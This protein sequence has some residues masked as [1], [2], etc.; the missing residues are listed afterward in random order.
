MKC[1]VTFLQQNIVAQVPAGTT[2]FDAANWAGLPI[3][4]TCGG[5]GACGKCKVKILQGANAQTKSDN[6]FLSSEESA[7]GW[8]LSCQAVVHADT[9]V[10][11]LRMMAAPKAATLVTGRKV[12]LDPNVRKF[13]LELP[14]PSLEDQR[15]DVKRVID[16]LNAKGF[17]V[18]AVPAVWRKLPTL[19][20]ENN[21]AITA[22]V[23]GDE[24]IAIEAG[25]TT[26]CVYGLA[27]DIGTTTVV[28]A[29]I[30]L[31]SGDVVAVQSVLNGQASF[32]ADVIA[33]ISY[34]LQEPNGLAL[35]HAAITETISDLIDVLVSVSGVLRENIYE[36]LAV[37]NATMMHLLL[38]I[39]PQAI[40]VEPFIPAI[41]EPVTL[42]AEEVGMR[43]HSE[44][45]LS[46]IP[47]LGAYV[48]ADIVAGVLATNLI[49]NKDDKLRLFIDVGT[50]G[51]IVLGSS[52]RALAT[53]AAAG[54][55]FEGAQ[56]M[57]GMRACEGAIEGVKIDDD[58]HLR[59]VGENARPRGIC[60]SGLID[61]AAELLRFGLM[62]S[63]G[64]LASPETVRGR[65]PD[66]LVNRLSVRDG[67][68]SFLLSSPEEGI[69]LTQADIRALQFAKA[70]IAS[71]TGIL[72]AKMGV[73]T[74]DLHETL[75]AGAFGSYI[76]PANARA[77]GLVPW[78]PLEQIAA[79][80]NAA[81]EG[82][83][84][85]LLSCREREA[86][87]HIP[88]FIEYTELSGRPEFNELFM[89]ELAFLS[90]ASLRRAEV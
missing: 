81:G 73:Q 76:S 66:A 83:R 48:G 34:A 87:F 58:V 77:I 22:V 10:A 24:L 12:M 57:C 28:G 54:P 42:I 37:G 71:A 84:I 85:A 46:V 62:D 43:L 14:L 39:N 5:R 70:A 88:D 72:M 75:L 63:S 38:E 41:Q 30:N 68:L 79:V 86:A 7:E 8:R 61:A 23:C 15:S 29:L 31:V 27:L 17:E 90:P 52:K 56:I 2:V 18:K 32:G 80:G 78:L 64:R 74:S 20:R 13:Y 16:A 11:A 44:T 3:D 21:F 19:L 47:H 59:I 4:G 6:R 53:A 40:G 35:L 36:I 82:A 49:R 50:N 51:E 33:R 69:V 26:K 65:L 67:S 45:R 89:K 60:G 55:A 9:V 1:Q 25:D